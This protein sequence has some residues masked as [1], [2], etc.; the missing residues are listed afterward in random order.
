MKLP[1]FR[2]A[3]AYLETWRSRET[4]RPLLLRGARQVGKSTLVRKHGRSYAHFFELNLELTADRALFD[5]LPPVEELADRIAL[6]FNV[7]KL[8]ENTL[9][10]IDEIQESPEAIQQLRFFYEK[11]PWLPVIAA[12]SL[13]EFV[14]GEV[15][16][17]P[18]GRVEFYTLHPLTF[19]EYLR[20][21]DKDI[22]ATAYNE[23]PVR[24]AVHQE[25]LRE[26]HRYSV[27]GGMPEIV[28]SISRGAN[29]AEVQNLYELIWSAYRGDAEK[30]AG[31][32]RQRQILRH[33]L[34][35]VAN[36][37]DRIKLA[38]FGGSNFRS[39]EVGPAFQAL[40][41]AGVLRLI[42]PTS[43][44]ALPV[45]GQYGRSPRVQL[46]DTGLLNYARGIQSDL[47]STDDLSTTY[48]GRI[49]QHI[50][51]QEI[52]ATHHEDSWQPYFWAREKTG[53]SAEVDLVLEGKKELYPLEV[54][55]GPQ[56]RL[57]S[58]H[59]FVERSP[60]K[61]GLRALRN[62]FSVQAVTTPGGVDYRLVN[63]PYYHVGF[64]G[65]YLKEA[66]SL[67]D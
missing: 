8:T 15:R 60:Q 38:R 29:I 36:E 30:Y 11:L 18:V 61:I 32:L 58:L 35:T 47:L 54:K 66:V 28:D 21:M 40:E 42:Y 26:F 23:V 41:R 39:D 27:I 9:L 48:R 51:T 55:A 49:A 34:S 22:L 62:E 63:I 45:V 24:K 53:S 1:K 14:L 33:L 57:R 5:G 12:G 44:V 19:Y 65:R 10:F 3:E 7:P 37:D 50:V 13:L 31:N 6:R 20:W 16:S 56:G 43:S 25:L 2:S 46:L 59:Q 64:W 4:R 52:I 67:I 17:F